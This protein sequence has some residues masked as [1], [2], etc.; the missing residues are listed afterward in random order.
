MRFRERRG[1]VV[2]GYWGLSGCNHPHHKKINPECDHREVDEENMREV[3]VIGFHAS[4]PVPYSIK[5]LQKDADADE[6]D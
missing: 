6:N 5:H 1:R 3:V 4:H 2:R